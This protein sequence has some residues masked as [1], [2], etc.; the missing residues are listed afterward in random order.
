MKRLE[1]AD[2]FIAR[3]LRVLALPYA[4]SDL[5]LPRPRLRPLLCLHLH[6][7]L[8]LHLPLL[9]LLSESVRVCAFTRAMRRPLDESP[10]PPPPLSL[11]WNCLKFSRCD[12]AFFVVVHFFDDDREYQSSP[13]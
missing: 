1:A 12:K 10:P 13:V 5:R 7:H 2:D 11:P 8:H 4:W 3:V 6:L 9:L